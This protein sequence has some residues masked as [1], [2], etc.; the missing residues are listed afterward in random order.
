MAAVPDEAFVHVNRFYDVGET[1]LEVLRTLA[2]STGTRIYY[3]GDDRQR[4]VP[5]AISP[6]EIV[7]K[8]SAGGGDVIEAEFG[9]VRPDRKEIRIAFVGRYG[10]EPRASEA[11]TMPVDRDR[12]ARFDR[13]LEGSAPPPAHVDGVEVAVTGV[14]I[15]V[16]A[17]DAQLVIRGDERTLACDMGWPHHLFLPSRDGDPLWSDWHPDDGSTRIEQTTRPDGTV[18]LSM[19][20]SVT[21][22]A[23]LQRD[24]AHKRPPTRELPPEPPPPV[25]VRTLPDRV[26][27]SNA[28]AHLQ[29]GRMHPPIEMHAVVTFA[30]PPREAAGLELNI[31]GL[32]LFRPATS[33]TLTVPTPRRGEDLDLHGYQFETEHGDV[34]L[35]RWEA[36]F[37][38][39]PTLV[40]RPPSP[41]W[42]PD[43]RVIYGDASASL[44]MRPG[45][46]GTVIG[47]L[48]AMY[49]E[50]FGDPAGV[51]LGL[52]VLGK[53]AARTRIELPLSVPAA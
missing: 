32:Y 1:R 52:R 35:V 49:R 10:E 9:P 12:T 29:R 51:R 36:G 43:V 40:V 41:F 13:E 24:A 17:G 34:V 23:S 53:P 44:W 26:A 14:R 6:P 5:R 39:L 21:V 33:K 4:L 20:N 22:T 38:E 11:I 42:Y 3:R 19:S 15:G 8:M 16:L 31:S 46:G 45:L 28:G 48:P 2:D 25:S 30:P 37:N 18:T 50:A 27:M 7:G 47:G